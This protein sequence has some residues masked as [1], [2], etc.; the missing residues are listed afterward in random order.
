MAKDVLGRNLNAE[1]MKKINVMT[2]R[3][4]K[5]RKIWDEEFPT[6]CPEG[7]LLFTQSWKETEGEPVDIRWAKAFANK[8]L[9]GGVDIFEDELIVGSLT[10][11]VKGVELMTSFRPNEIASMVK[12]GRF[13]R[14]MSA[15]TAAKI[16]PEDMEDLKADVDYWLKNLPPDYINDALRKELGEGHFELMN[17]ASCVLE[18]PYLRKN[19]ERG[20]FA[21]VGSWG[22]VLALHKEIID[23]GLKDVLRV[24][25]EEIAKMEAEGVDYK[26]EGTEANKKYNYIQ[27]IIITTDAII[28][29][30]HRYADEARRLAELETN[31]T[32]KKELLQ[33]AENCDWVP[34]NPPRTYWEA[35]QACRFLHLA[36]RKE[37][38]HRPENSV[39]RLDQILFPYYKADVEAGRIDRQFASEL[40]GCFWLKTREGEVLQVQ[41]PATRIA[42]G[43]NLPNMTICGTDGNGHDETN[44]MSWI[45]LEVM[46]QIRL[47]E[48]AVYIR[49]H[50]G[51]DEDF[52]LYALECNK[53][54]QGGIP[55]FLSDSL[56]AERYIARGIAKEDAY[57]WAASGCLGYHLDCSE[58]A[59]GSMHINQTKVLELVYNNGFD[60]LT[61]KQIAPKT[62]DPTTFKTYEEFYN[63]F[64]EMEDWAGKALHDDYAIRWR[65]DIAHNFQ[66]GLGGMMLYKYSIPIGKCPSRGGCKY[67]NTFTGWVGDRGTTDVADALAATKYLVYDEKKCTM[68]E[69]ITAMKANWE[70][71][72][73]LHQ[74]CLK[75]PKYGNDD[76]Y[77]DSIFA[78]L[79]RDTQR[80]LESRPDPFTGEKPILFKGAASGHIL[81]G[82]HVGALPNGRSL[83]E[84][85]N[86][87]GTSAMP[88]M[89]V[90]G[91]T[92]LVNS[93]T[94]DNISWETF[95][96]TH[97]M[98][99][100]SNLFNNIEKLK[101][102]L[103]MVKVF[104][105][106]GGWHI[107]FNITD[108]EELKAAQIDPAKW[109]NL[110][111]RVG[112]YSAY[113]V[114]LP[115]TLQNEIIKRTEH[116][117]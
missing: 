59:G 24:A 20:L 79:I 78:Q 108:A 11:N 68:E 64:L 105:Q 26:T 30:A 16:D 111:V 86:D 2:E 100:A 92:A 40:L 52:L 10:K 88:G 70:G 104:F 85:V 63:A 72:E 80:I 62:G 99:F 83:G 65:E 14:N 90:K 87:A 103:A 69:L 39:G 54:M 47:S 38:P 56:G 89:D 106:R 48:P 8:L 109:K 91:P 3:V 60:P 51:L 13:A 73:D 7:T 76:E 35:V 101:L 43:T 93:A 57:N 17:D 77:V 23:A 114:D 61:G 44:E 42:P 113:F 41:P 74:M 32:R 9:K 28:K 45:I 95:G 117:V 36:V 107:Q 71:Y 15:N 33:I 29:W 81:H 4:A 34:E 49:Y 21:D 1:E 82:F 50:E 6:V 58:H 84:S 46:R 75:A 31:E 22:G 66:S 12:D 53:D 5:R 67:P 19:P 27:A 116:V 110:M 102:I 25:N 98:K 96:N 115:E 94:C 55:A 97:N 37:Q 18:G 112:G